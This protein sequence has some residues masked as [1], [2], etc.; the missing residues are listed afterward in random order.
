MVTEKGKKTNNELFSYYF[1]CS[2]PS[3]MLSRLSN[4]RGEISEQQVYSINKTLSKIKNIVKNV[5]K[6]DPLKTE[7]NEKIIDIVERIL[8]LNSENQLG[9]GLNILTS[10]QMLSR[11]P[12]S[13]AQF[14]QEII[15]RNSKTKLGNY[16]ILRT[17]QRNLQNNS[18]K[19]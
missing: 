14:K 2:S 13:L 6:D 9:L 11:L 5:R 7:E 8:E 4:A 10:N 18:I 1:N 15:Q 17:D 12:I 3:N 19:V 16:C